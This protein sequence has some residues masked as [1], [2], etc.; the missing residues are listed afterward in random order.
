MVVVHTIPT[1][2]QLIQRLVLAGGNQLLPT[3]GQC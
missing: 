3:L 1:T 2:Y